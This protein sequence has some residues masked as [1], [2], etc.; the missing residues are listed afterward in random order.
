MAIDVRN[1]HNPALTSKK[2]S[3]PEAAEWHNGRL[4]TQVG[5]GLAA[6]V[7]AFAP[8]VLGYGSEPGN[9]ASCLVQE[10]SY[11]TMIRSRV[12]NGREH[13]SD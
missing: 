8:S 11:S 4:C 2:E 12:L 13:S 5:R 9:G 6:W 3:D 10:S 1:M 7:G